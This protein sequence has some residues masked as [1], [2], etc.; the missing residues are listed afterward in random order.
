[1][2]YVGSKNRLSKYLVPI[3]QK[4]IDDNNVKQYMEIFVGG[5]NMID[6]IKCDKKIG[7]D[8][9]EE[10]IELLKYSQNLNNKFPKTITEKEYYH[11]RNNKEK[12]PKWYVG[13]VGFASTFGAKY[14]G[15]YARSYKSDGIT[16]RDMPNEGI[17]NI[18]RQRKDLKNIH[19][20]CMDFLDIPK[21]K[22]KNYVIYCDA[23]YKNTTKYKTEKFPYEDFYNW[24]RDMSKNNIVIISEYN[25]P[26][27][28]KCIWSKEHKTILDVKRHKKKNRK[29]IYS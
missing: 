17:R 29:I 22:I 27:D 6:K 14:F 24:C 21:D 8:I 15:G 16:L 19:F 2:K 3:I 26:N 20:G 11:V 1:M 12:Y 7:L 4:Y 5:S 9:H 13:L 28:F 23:P 10:L 25:M 18:E